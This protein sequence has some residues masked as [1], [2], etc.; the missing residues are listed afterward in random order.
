MKINN[1]K[2]IIQKS[3]EDSVGLTSYAL[4][5]NLFNVDVS[6]DKNYQRN[7]TS[8]YK[9]RRDEKWLEKYYEFMEQHKHD[10]SLTF[11]VVL[12]YISSIPHSVGNHIN[13][14]GQSTSIEASFASKML[15][16]ID[17]TYP[18]WD[19]QVV[20]A[21]GYKIRAT[22]K[23]EKILEYINLYNHLT[24]EMHE[25]IS[26]GEGKECIRLFDEMFPNYKH[27]S[28]VKKIDFYLWN[29]GK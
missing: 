2:Q 16:T 3:I 26:T 29:I 4:T 1:P 20:K 28:D 15:S 18:V 11:E 13:A 8:Y 21:L 9:V 12:R 17:P 24:K 6:K 22:N 23:E 19:S 10:D 7:F 27:I 25:Y 14:S 5:L